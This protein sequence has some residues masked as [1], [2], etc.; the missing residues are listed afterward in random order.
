MKEV[1]PGIFLIKE[2]GTIG[3]VKPPEN[4][5][6]IAGKDGLIFDGGYGNR[7]TVR[8]VIEEINKIRRVYFKKKKTFQVTRVLPSHVHPDHFSGLKALKRYLNINILLT[9]KMAEVIQ[10]RQ[11]FYDYYESNNYFKQNFIKDNLRNVLKF[12][13]RKPLLR[14]FYQ[15]IYGLSFIQEPDEIIDEKTKI[16]IY[17]QVWEIFPSP[18]HSSDHISLYNEPE[19]VLFSGDNILRTVTTWLGPP[20]SD[21]EEYIHTIKKIRALPNLKLILPAHGSPITQPYER[22]EE[23][24][25]HR[26]HRTQQVLKIVQKHSNHGI[27]PEEIIEILYTSQ[28]RMMYGVARGWVVL[29]LHMLVE[30]GRIKYLIKKEGVKFYSA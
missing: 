23:I 18:G 4:I 3:A 2:K 20:N 25:E 15:I 17:N 30:K 6:V 10:S 9:E 5:Y 19:G 8:H 14:F 1:Y 13:L 12:Q 21:I 27:T 16:T 7:K 29:T 28:G 22:I 11:N 24:L 26:K